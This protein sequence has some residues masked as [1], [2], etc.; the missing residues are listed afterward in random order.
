VLTTG[1]LPS[2]IS[3]QLVLICEHFPYE[4]NDPASGAVIESQL[5]GVLEFWNG[6]GHGDTE[7]ADTE[8]RSIVLGITRANDVGSRDSEH[9]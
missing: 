2:S 1:L 6:V 7:T 9:F 4:I 5:G 8:K 3:A